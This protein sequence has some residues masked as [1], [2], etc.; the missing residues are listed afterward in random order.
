MKDYLFVYLL[1]WRE[2]VR[3]RE[4]YRGVKREGE[5]KKKRKS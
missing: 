5:K 2:S 1:F 3:A 4:R